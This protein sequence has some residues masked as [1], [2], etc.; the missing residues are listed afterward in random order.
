VGLFS[1]ARFATAAPPSVV[2]PADAGAHVGTVVTVEGEVTAARTEGDTCV[3]EFGPDA[4]GF[5]VVLLVPVFSDLPEHPERL[6]QGRRIRATGRIQRFRG[7]PEMVVRGTNRIEVV[8]FGATPPATAAPLPPPA[9]PPATVTPPAAPAPVT[10]P[11]TA[12]AA[13][14]AAAPTPP[15]VTILPAEDRCARA[16]TRWRDAGTVAREHAAALARC[17]EGSSYRCRPESERLAPALSALEWAE[18]Q[19][20]AACR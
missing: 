16:R 2:S 5:R 9:G 7:A 12:P 18:Q 13:P 20:E 6:Y 4:G 10:P 1:A 17:L 3:M 19:V 14:P 8:G 11:A 15:P